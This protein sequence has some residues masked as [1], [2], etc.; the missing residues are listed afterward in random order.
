MYKSAR[1]D[2]LHSSYN[3]ATPVQKTKVLRRPVE[4]AGVLSLSFQQLGAYLRRSAVS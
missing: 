2:S 3:Y 1:L 4:V